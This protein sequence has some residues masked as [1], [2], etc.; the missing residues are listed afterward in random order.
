MRRTTDRR[1]HP[2]RRI[3]SNRIESLLRPRRLRTLRVVP[4]L[5]KVAGALPRA[6][7][8]QARV[9]A[10]GRGARVQAQGGDDAPAPTE[11][12]ADQRE[13]RAAAERERDAEH[14]SEE[15]DVIQQGGRAERETGDAAARGEAGEEP[16]RVDG[17]Q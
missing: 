16:P 15:R 2:A 4:G 7:G 10:P 5:A 3:E 12:A 11:V 17:Q 14:G 6:D 8:V 9:A 13:D 1:V